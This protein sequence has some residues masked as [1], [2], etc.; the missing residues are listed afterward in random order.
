MESLADQSPRYI[1]D[2]SPY[3]ILALMHTVPWHQGQALKDA[4][5]DHLH[6]GSSF[7]VHIPVSL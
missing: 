5:L 4:I 3:F 6:F 1:K 7:R 2:L